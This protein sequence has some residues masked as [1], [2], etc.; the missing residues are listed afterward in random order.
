MRSFHLSANEKLAAYGAAAVLIGGFVGFWTG[1]L[2]LLAMVASIGM[3]AVVF[4]SRKGNRGSIMLALGG[5]AGVV[6]VFGLLGRLG[7][8]GLMLTAAP[9]P[10]I[11]YLVAICGGVVMAWAGWREFSTPATT[12]SSGDNGGERP[13]T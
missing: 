8:I 9:V 2:G 5:V 6:L 12:G 10:T 13:S 4:R 3:L 1:A 7:S 11:F